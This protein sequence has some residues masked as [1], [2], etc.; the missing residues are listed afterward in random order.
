MV[1]KE[2]NGKTKGE[3]SKKKTNI[4]IFVAQ[5]FILCSITSQSQTSGMTIANELFIVRHTLKQTVASFL[6]SVCP[7]C[8]H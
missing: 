3:F 6:C 4:Q 1:E 5:N 2:E 7:K 8:I